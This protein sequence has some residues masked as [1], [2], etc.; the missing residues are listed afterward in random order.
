MGRPSK[1]INI[2]QGCKFS[3]FEFHK[4]QNPINSKFKIR[5][6][7]A[8]GGVAGSEEDASLCAETLD[9]DDDGDEDQR[10]ENTRDSSDIPQVL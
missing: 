2:A 9:A 10:T 7:P 3:K 4:N 6:C 8:Q 1:S 5:N